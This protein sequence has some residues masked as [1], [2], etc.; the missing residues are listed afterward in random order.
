MADEQ[1]FFNN[2]GGS[3]GREQRNQLRAAGGSSIVDCSAP[4]YHIAKWKQFEFFV[5][6]STDEVGRRGDIYE[7]PLSDYIGYK[8]LG[9]KASRFKLEGYLIGVDQ[10]SKT[11]EIMR[12]ARSPEP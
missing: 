9:A 5:D 11:L 10:L 8:D 4:T 3:V 2:K 12:E 1:D 6:T 7:Y